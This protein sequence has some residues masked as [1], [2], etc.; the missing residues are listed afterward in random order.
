VGEGEEGGQTKWA[1]D[2]S[3]WFFE[4]CPQHFPTMERGGCYLVATA[5]NP[6][7]VKEM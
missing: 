2:I 1:V 4:V 5:C 3:R 6:A 7:R